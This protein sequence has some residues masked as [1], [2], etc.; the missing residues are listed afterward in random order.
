MA[1]S[2]T[3]HPRPIVGMWL[4]VLVA[5]AVALAIWAIVAI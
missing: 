1:P 3:Q 5:M 2:D 4:V